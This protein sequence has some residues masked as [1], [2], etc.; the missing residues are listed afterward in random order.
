M[1][2]LTQNERD[3]LEDVFSSIHSCDTNH[4][5]LKGVLP[6]IMFIKRYFLETKFYKLAKY[7]VK[8][9]Y[10]SHFSSFKHKKKKNLSK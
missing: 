10:F 3:G 8:A 4:R 9:I 6:L 5:L 1:S 7:G 2:I